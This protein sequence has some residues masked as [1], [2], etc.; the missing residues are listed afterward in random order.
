[1]KLGFFVPNLLS[2]SGEDKVIGGLERYSWALIELMQELGWDVEVN[3]NG[4]SDWKQEVNGIIIKGHEVARYSL[5]AV[6]EKI[7]SSYG[8]VLYGSL[9]QKPI[10]YKSNSIVISHGVWWDGKNIAREQRERMIKICQEAIAQNALTISCDYNFLN[11]MRAISPEVT[12]KIRVI[13]NFVNINKFK[14]VERDSTDTI[15]ILYPRRLDYCR[16]IDIF[17]EI[18]KDLIS[19]RSNLEILMAVDKNHPDF[20]QQLKPFLS[21]NQVRE[22]NPQFE[23]MPDIYQQ[24]D[25]VVIP[26]RYSEGS[27]FSCLEAMASGKAI[28]ASDVG[29]LTN[30]IINGYNGILVP[31]RKTPITRAINFLLDNHSARQKL[32][33]NAFKTAR[34]FTLE[35]WKKQWAGYLKAIYATGDG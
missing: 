31:P 11:V 29:G 17:I 7:N 9:L 27:S 16:G 12:D 26:S 24:A 1:M 30:L 25:I 33:E 32:G 18:A 10:Y 8:R 4:N 5:E 13:P 28:V 6:V 19:Q 35:R 34:S 2:W 23:D 15:K 21:L 3:Q 14:K 20:N 22:F